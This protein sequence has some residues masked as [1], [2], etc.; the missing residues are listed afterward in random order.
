MLIRRG[1]FVLMVIL[2]FTS[3]AGGNGSGLIGREAIEQ[4]H[5]LRCFSEACIADPSANEIAGG[6]IESS[7]SFRE[8]ANNTE[9]TY[10]ALG[11]FDG[12]A[13]Q[14]DGMVVSIQKIVHQTNLLALNA[15][16]E[17]A[18][19]VKNL[20][21]GKVAQQAILPTL[22]A[23]HQID[24]RI[25]TLAGLALPGSPAHA[26]CL[27]TALARRALTSKRVEMHSRGGRNSAAMRTAPWSPARSRRPLG[28]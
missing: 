3:A 25:G 24:V 14:I 23:P 21:V 20:P 26:G 8:A 2:H 12:T 10:T 27:R 9:A 15:A 13:R 1:T 4:G 17:S 7:C 22:R 19:A 6:A 11:A 16:I 28:R 18:R 5:C